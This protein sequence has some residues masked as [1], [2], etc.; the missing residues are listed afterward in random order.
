[1]LACWH[2]LKGHCRRI[3]AYI[4]AVNGLVAKRL[5]SKGCACVPIAIICRHECIH[6]ADAEE[7]RASM[8]L[9]HPMMK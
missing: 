5:P 6:R 7:V 3:E 8:M 9:L 4:A 1:M 2:E